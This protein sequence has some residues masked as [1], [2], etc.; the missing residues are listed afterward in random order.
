[1][2]SKEKLFEYLYRLL[3]AFLLISLAGFISKFSNL[4][5]NYIDDRYHQIYEVYNTSFPD[6]LLDYVNEELVASFPSYWP[7][8]LIGYILTIAYCI[9]ANIFIPFLILSFPGFLVMLL[10]HYPYKE[11]PKDKV[12]N[13]R[14]FIF[15]IMFF[16]ISLIYVGKRLEED[17]QEIIK[18]IKE[19][20]DPIIEVKSEE[21]SSENGNELSDSN[22]QKQNQIKEDK[23]EEINPENKI[24][25][26][27]IKEQKEVIYEDK[28]LPGI[29]PVNQI[30]LLDSI[31]N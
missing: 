19:K 10:L 16:F 24:G 18:T 20:P 26:F 12:Y 31:E 29:I 5:T 21:V 13:F 23:M 17:N 15:S 1:M 3:L 27:D 7:Y 2:F 22:I 30:G 8:I 28:N 25:F 4:A 14:V 6:Y 9:L 11:I